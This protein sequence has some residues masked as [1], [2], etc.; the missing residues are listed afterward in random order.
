MKREAGIYLFAVL[1]VV[2]VFITFYFF[3]IKPTGFAVFSGQPDLS[4]GTYNNTVYSGSAVILNSSANA[5]SGS[6][7]SAVLDS[8]NTN[9]TWNNLTWTGTVPANSSLSFQAM[10]CSDATC[11]NVTFTGVT[12]T[13]NT[14][15]LSGLGTGQ[16]LQY[17]AL[18]SIPNLNISSPSL[19]GASY[20]Y[21]T[22]EQPV[23][24][25]ITVHSP[26]NS[27]YDSTTVNLSVSATQDV[28]GWWYILNAGSNTSFTPNTTITA[29]EGSNSV[30]V[31]ANNTEG[32]VS[33]K[34]VSFTVQIPV[35]DSSHLSACSNYLD[36]NN[37]GGYWWD[38]NTCNQESQAKKNQQNTTT[39]QQNNV[40]QEP[41]IPQITRIVLG[42]ISS[43]DIIQGDSKDLTLTVQ[44]TGTVPVSACSL[45]F[46][47]DNAAW[48]STSAGAQSITAAGASSAS[49]PFS[50]DI[51]LET[52]PGAYDLGMTVTCAEKTETGS[53]A[54]NVIQKKFDFNIT[55]VQRTSQNKVRIDYSIKDLIGEKQNISVF[56][57]I[58]DNSS[59]DVGN[60]SQNKTLS[61]NKTSTYNVNIPINETLEGNLTLS[62]NVNSEQYSSS[63]LQPISL[64][65]P[66]G[67]F[68]IFGGQGGAGSII[69]LIILVAVLA[70]VFF[71]VRKMR[72][73]KS[74]Q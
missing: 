62:A 25:S 17:K 18:F 36:C 20:S 33:Y 67:G 50:V 41:V 49:Y 2:A 69:I 47:G 51:P 8:N 39:Q 27:T 10:I 64:G 56:F 37:E 60:I 15:D 12:S 59:K 61:A 16:Y 11:S 74:S 58:I 45:T 71:V 73:A 40:T 21:T 22:Q 7:I 72:K 53:V 68:A 14:I 32:N 6:Y 55:N 30:T 29:A 65:A 44:N 1:L 34:A 42:T 57:S 66:I 46:T 28:S 5:T 63:V 9:T 38:D 54:I 31:Y 4:T 26:T 35:C 23:E 48:A 52:A 70:A 13:N 43:Q 24:F 19:T 3:N